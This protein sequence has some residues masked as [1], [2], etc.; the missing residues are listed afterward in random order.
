LEIYATGLGPVSDAPADGSAASSTPL[1]RTA[2]T[3]IVNI[4]GTRATV[5]FSGLAPGLAGVYQINAQ[6]ADTAPLGDRIPVTI[7]VG[8]QGT[9]SNTATIAIE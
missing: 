8:E 3:T 5:L 7:Q 6:I 9:S 1:S 2:G 4:A